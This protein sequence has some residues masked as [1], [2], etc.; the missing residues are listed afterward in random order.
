MNGREWADASFSQDDRWK[1]LI[2]KYMKAMLPI[3]RTPGPGAQITACMSCAEFQAI[4]AKVGEAARA[5]QPA[6]SRESWVSEERFFAN[7]NV[8]IFELP[9]ELR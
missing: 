4:D 5:S 1:R 6:A 9:V 8:V 2:S 3:G 7:M